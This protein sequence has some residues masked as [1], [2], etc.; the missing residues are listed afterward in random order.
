MPKGLR[1]GTEGEIVPERERRVAVTGD[2]GFV[3]V[4]EE[5]D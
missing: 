4:D 3:A 2:A 5:P 1:E